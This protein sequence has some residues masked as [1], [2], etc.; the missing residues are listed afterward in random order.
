MENQNN[1]A[2]LNAAREAKA[3][4]EQP[5]LTAAEAARII[6][7]ENATSMVGALAATLPF[8]LQ[9]AES[10]GG[11]FHLDFLADGGMKLNAD[12][13][14]IARAVE[15]MEPKQLDLMFIMGLFLIQQAESQILD[16]QIQHLTSQL[17]QLEA[18]G[19]LKLGKEV[20][21]ELV[22]MLVAMQNQASE[23]TDGMVA[24]NESAAPAVA[25]SL[26]I[27]DGGASGASIGSSDS[28]GGGE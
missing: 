26:G 3:A 16:L 14:G 12:G 10:K 13:L 4:A 20:S 28:A 8:R 19:A 6:V 15:D 5:N 18:D 24:A 7:M 27:N 9:A 17:Q 23:V 11:R 1:V 21:P 2:D 22:G 25:T